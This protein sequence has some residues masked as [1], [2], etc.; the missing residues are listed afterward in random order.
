MALTCFPFLTQTITRT[1]SWLYS[2]SF[3]TLQRAPNFS[4]I[5]NFRCKF[6]SSLMC[7]GENKLLLCHSHFFCHWIRVAFCP[8]SP[9]SVY[10]SCEFSF[11]AINKNNPQ[12]FSTWDSFCWCLAR[13]VLSPRR[14]KPVSLSAWQVN[15]EISLHLSVEGKVF[16]SDCTVAYP[17]REGD[18]KQHVA[19]KGW[20]L[21][22]RILKAS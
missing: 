21:R 19:I 20:R 7:R 17:A 22:V 11:F 8:V 2:F 10:G 15:D 9:F 5:A 13:P 4:W 1:W 12:L 6:T 18:G 3:A 16:L 14:L